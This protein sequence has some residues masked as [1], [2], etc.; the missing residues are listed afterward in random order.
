MYWRSHGITY[1]PTRSVTFWNVIERGY[2]VK[3]R[4]LKMIV[5]KLFK[6]SVQRGYHV[7]RT[8]YN[9]AE[10]DITRHADCY[11]MTLCTSLHPRS[12]Y[13]L[14]RYDTMWHVVLRYELHYATMYDIVLRFWYV[15]WR[16]GTLCHGVKNFRLHTVK[17]G[18]Y[19]WPKFSEKS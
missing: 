7:A 13:A 4:E 9:V 11:V 18:I 2:A 5:F 16:Y 14:S 10:R 3:Q 8:L 6:N 19:V 15:V 17:S 12:T 1:W